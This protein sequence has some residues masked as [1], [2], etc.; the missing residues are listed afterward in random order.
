ML[1]K[2]ASSPT[3]AGPTRPVA[4][5]PSISGLAIGGATTGSSGV[6]LNRCNSAENRAGRLAMSVVAPCSRRRTANPLDQQC[7]VGVEPA[8]SGEVELQRHIPT[9]IGGR[10]SQHALDR[11]R[12]V[13]RP[14]AAATDHQR[15]RCRFPD[16]GGR[17]VHEA[18]ELPA[19]GRV[20]DASL[21]AA[22]GGRHQ[23]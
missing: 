9:A 14:V 23:S 1:E 19:N 18:Q 21:A 15:G 10:R 6:R 11:V 7:T 4:A 12:V 3:A 22:A 5:S 16:R 2:V 17:S 13:G 20:K 8:D